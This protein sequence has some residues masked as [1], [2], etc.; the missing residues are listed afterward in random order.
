MELS[1]YDVELLTWMDKQDPARPID[2]SE[3]WSD[4]AVGDF[5]RATASKNDDNLSPAV[6]R[7]DSED[8]V[9]VLGNPNNYELGTTYG[10]TVAYLKNEGFYA[11]IE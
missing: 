6:K 11:E 1:T 10:E 9:E 3:G 2:H 4:C 7:P 8:L 5:A